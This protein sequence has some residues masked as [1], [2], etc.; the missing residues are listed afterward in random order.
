MPTTT[1]PTTHRLY[2]PGPYYAAKL[3]ATLPLNVLIAVA[4]AWTGYGMFGFRHSALAVVQARGGAGLRALRA[5]R[6]RAWRRVLR[7]VLLLW[8]V[9]CASLVH[10][11]APRPAEHHYHVRCISLVHTR[12]PRP[13]A[14]LAQNTATTCAFS[15]VA[16]QW[17]FFATMVAPNQ[18]IAF[19]LAVSGAALAQCAL[20]G[21]GALVAARE[22]P[23]CCTCHAALIGWGRMAHAPGARLCAL[24]VPSCAAAAAA[25]HTPPEART[26]RAML[27]SLGPPHPSPFP[28]R[29]WPLPW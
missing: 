18:D 11:R 3:T 24:C 28:V 17:M 9:R 16:L 20:G 7:A 27:P 5:T 1:T 15:L 14:A 23:S 26:A 4:F 25:Q 10:A 19:V 13:C 2:S 29:R 8:G 22:H 12:A 21:L 6:A